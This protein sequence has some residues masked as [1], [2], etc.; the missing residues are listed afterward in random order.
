MEVGLAISKSRELI[1]DR[2]WE[3]T[4]PY[5]AITTLSSQALI[6]T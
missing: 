6:K 1:V 4:K 2:D 5:L 3:I